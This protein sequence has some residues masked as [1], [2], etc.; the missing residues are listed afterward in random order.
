MSGESQIDKCQCPEFLHNSEMQCSKEG[1][2]AVLTN[3]IGEAVN[4][5]LVG[6]WRPLGR[7]DSCCQAHHADLSHRCSNLRV[8][9]QNGLQV[10]CTDMAGIAS[11]K[12]DLPTTQP[13]LRYTRFRLDLVSYLS[14]TELQFPTFPHGSQARQ[15]VSPSSFTGQLFLKDTQCACEFGIAHSHRDL[16]LHLTA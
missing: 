8:A 14:R 7:L 15:V 13:A 9:Y 2:G 11:L 1:V 10:T 4:P 12:Q 6:L 16:F 3:N 5:G